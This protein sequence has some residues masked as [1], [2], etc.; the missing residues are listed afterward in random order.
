MIN[1]NG[2]IRND[3]EANIQFYKVVRVIP[4]KYYVININTIHTNINDSKL[5]FR[6]CKNLLKKNDFSLQ[7]SI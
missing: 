2:I 1:N 6:K 5:T 4:Q 7:K 3:I